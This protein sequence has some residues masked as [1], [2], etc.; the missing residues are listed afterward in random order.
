[1]E[2]LQG[3]AGDQKVNGRINSSMLLVTIMPLWLRIGSPWGILS[4]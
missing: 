1:M 2:F 3:V 4:L